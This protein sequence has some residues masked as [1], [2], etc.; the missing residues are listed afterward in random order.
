MILTNQQIRIRPRGSNSTFTKLLPRS[1]P[2]VS[3]HTRRRFVNKRKFKIQPAHSRYLL[4]SSY[5]VYGAYAHVGGAGHASDSEVVAVAAA[6]TSKLYCDDPLRVSV[7][8]N[9]VRELAREPPDNEFS[10]LLAFIGIVFIYSFVTAYGALRILR[11][12]KKSPPLTPLSTAC[13]RRVLT[14]S[15]DLHS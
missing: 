7:A 9:Y 10:R 11:C 12:K 5:Q 4:L 8:Y 13:H 3:Q 1:L 2:R 15:A 6:S 14:S